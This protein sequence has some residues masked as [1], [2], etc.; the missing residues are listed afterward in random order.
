MIGFMGI[1]LHRDR[2]A[3]SFFDAIRI[4]RDLTIARFYYFLY[5]C[6][7]KTD[8]IAIHFGRP[9]KLAKAIE[10][11]WNVFLCDTCTSILHF[12]GKV[13]RHAIICGIYRYCTIAC[14][15]YSILHQVNQNLF[16]PLHVTN[17]LR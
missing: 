6:K 2:E 3:A 10:E 15:L 9:V 12:H 4:Y 1:H 8:A 7:A 14:E 5:D 17:Q 16:E 11:L 13:G